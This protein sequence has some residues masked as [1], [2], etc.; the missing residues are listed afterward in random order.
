MQSVTEPA[1]ARPAPYC[2]RDRRVAKDDERSAGSAGEG[3]ELVLHAEG[4]EDFEHRGLV[5]GVEGCEVGEL[6]AEEVLGGVQRPA[7]GVGDD[8]VV[9]AD[10]EGLGD[11]D[12]GLEAGGDPAV[13]VAADLAA[14]AVDLLGEFAL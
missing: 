12:E 14:V 4:V 6:V 10:V 5:V 9:D 11:P 7:V 13:L 8:E 1:A 2:G 3:L